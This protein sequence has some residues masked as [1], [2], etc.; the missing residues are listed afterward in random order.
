VGAYRGK[1]PVKE[2]SGNALGPGL[3]VARHL[4]LVFTKYFGATELD[5]VK[6]NLRTLCRAERRR[7]GDVDISLTAEVYSQETSRMQ[8][9]KGED[10]GRLVEEVFSLECRNLYRL[11]NM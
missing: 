6:G 4:E 1:D 2:I 5:A 11:Q 3:T 7:L 8:E 10:C 9:M